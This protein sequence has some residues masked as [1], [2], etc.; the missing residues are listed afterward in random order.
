MP[1]TTRL[2]L[3]YLLASQSDKHVTFNDAMTHLDKLIHLCVQSQSL[4]A[5]PMAPNEGMNY[6][7]PVGAS[8]AWGSATNDVAC[9]VDGGWLFLSPREGWQAWVVD[10]AH[11]I[12]FAS[13]NWSKVPIVET[14]NPVAMVGINTIADPVNRLAIKSDA[15]L[16]S[17]EPDGTG[18]IQVK[19]NK[20]SASATSSLLFQT[21]WQSK[22]EIGLAGDDSFRIKV[23]PN[24]ANFQTALRIDPNTASVE[25][26]GGLRD[27]QTGQRALT[28]VS[29]PVRDIW[30]SDMDAPAT[31]RSYVVSSVTGNAVTIATNEVEQM[32]N[33]GMRDASMVRIWNV[34]KAPAQ[35][36]WINW[37][38]AA[39]VFLVHNG[40]DV[41][42]WAT[43]DQ[44]RF[45]DPNPTGTNVLQMVALDISNYLFN[46][47]GKVFP[48]RGVKMSVGVPGIAGRASL[49]CSGNGAIGSAFGGSSAPDGQRQSVFVDIFTN[50]LSPISNSNLLFFSESFTTPATALGATRLLRLA[51]IW[52]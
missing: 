21:D 11:M 25:C 2:N 50:T 4:A 9:F 28:L 14:V 7:I 45:G 35:A 5:P 6:V 39:N 13:G 16:L 32:F 24:G 26:V 41:A 51:G 23:S 8:V 22:A 36:A 31:P 52:V 38:A 15:V 33:N 18:N 42:S 34:S 44:L 48:Q 1:R 49:T 29:A 30:R 46:N 17:H 47:F 19:L 37:N 40:G 43:G 12:R 20:S 27:P 10:G 3:P